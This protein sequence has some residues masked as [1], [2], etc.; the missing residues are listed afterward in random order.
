MYWKKL[1]PVEIKERVFNALSENINYRTSPVLGI[2]GTFLDPEEFYEDA[3]FL[4]NSPFLSALIANPNHIGCHT[5]VAPSLPFSGTQKLEAELIKLCAEQIF[6]GEKDAQD[7]YVASGGTEAN[8]QAMWIYR[9][10]FKAVHKAKSEEIALV[11]SADSHYS[12]PKGANLLELQSIVLPVNDDTRAIE[13]AGLEALLNNAVKKGIKH[14]IVVLNMGTTMFGSIDDLDAL[15]VVLN[16]MNLS[17]KL[18]VDAAF[19]GFIY[20][21]T[22]GENSFSFRNS[23]ISSF[24]IDAHKL[25]Q[26]PYGTGIFL[27]RKGMMQYALTEEASYIPG[28]DYTICGSRSGA[29]AVSV[30]MILNGHGSEGWKAKMQTLISR[31]IDICDRLDELG[32]KYYND[33]FMNIITIKS[34]CISRE[35]AEKYLLVADNYND[36]KWWKIVMMPHVKKGTIDRFLNE[37]SKQNIPAE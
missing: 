17:Y 10:Y 4:D 22:N 23:D 28:K 29:N 5:L 14:F 12:M 34:E 1:S 7:G 3:P 2:P 24:T 32:V 16:G 37:L 15:T 25:L 6:G 13:V 8:I 26:A 36:P 9:N 19:G 18:H 30:W 33:P 35:L 11:H 31:T 27:V 21:F 20:P